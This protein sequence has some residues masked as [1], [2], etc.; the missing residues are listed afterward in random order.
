MDEFAEA[1]QRAKKTI[2]RDW[3]EVAST[4]TVGWGWPIEAVEA[5]IPFLRS[6]VTELAAVISRHLPI[7]IFQSRESPP[8]DTDVA[9][10][11]RDAAGNPYKCRLACSGPLTDERSQ[12]L[13]SFAQAIWFALDQKMLPPG[14]PDGRLDKA[15]LAWTGP[16]LL[17]L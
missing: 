3:Q 13:G 9:I 15:L 12:L 4:R 16:A 5:S 2:Q 14:G 11:Y 17:R 7:L 1:R 10:P 6:H 8:T